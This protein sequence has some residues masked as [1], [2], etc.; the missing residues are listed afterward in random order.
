MKRRTLLMT[1]SVFLP[2]ISKGAERLPQKV[3]I[4]VIGSGGAG[5]CAACA[6]MQAGPRMS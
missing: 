4:A 1:P 5:S 2:F 3:E 6:A